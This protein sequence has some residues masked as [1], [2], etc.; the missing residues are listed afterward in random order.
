M[1]KEIMEKLETIGKDWETMKA[2]GEKYHKEVESLG[3]A[4]GET[5]ALLTK[6]NAN[7]DK[8][9]D[10]IKSIQEEIEKS[11]G[12]N[13][14][15]DKIDAAIKRNGGLSVSKQTENMSD[16][17]LLYKDVFMKSLTHG[18]LEQGGGPNPELEKAYE[19]M[20]QNDKLAKNLA[21]NF[22]P[23]AGFFVPADMSGRISTVIYET[24]NMRQVC[25]VQQISTDALEGAIDEGRANFNWVGE[26]ETPA[27]T[28]LPNRGMWRIPTHEAE[29]RILIT[30]KLLED[31]V[32][33]Q[34]SWAINK[35]AEEFALGEETAFVNGDGKDKPRG[36]LTYPD[37]SPVNGKMTRGQIER[38][39]TGVNGDLT[40]PDVL[41]DMI[42]SQ[43]K[44]NRDNSRFAFAREGIFKVRLLR[45][46]DKYVWQPGLQAGEPDRLFGY[47]VEEMNDIPD[48]ATGSLSGIFADFNKGYQIV[49][50]IQMAMLRDPYTQKPFVEIY[51]RKRVG[52]DV[53]NFD[54]IKVL[55]ASAP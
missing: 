46:D 41:L 37:G 29:A 19:D 53:R 16:E 55:E 34:E 26:T 6:V 45:M 1:S 39:I 4:S 22:E 48:F 20:I 23:G 8:T 27:Q 17:A 43:K 36:I 49:D 28:N 7:I 54:C 47:A 13:E 11:K 50:R 18:G 2:E 38:I 14:R 15:L 31:S 30:Q 12:I 10:E 21:V 42:Y 25:A 24:S 9:Q 44:A 32:V 5:T 33:D 52:G 3:K 51:A 35:I 40:N